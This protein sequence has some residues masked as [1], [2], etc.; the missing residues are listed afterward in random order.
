MSD[1][2]FRFADIEFGNSPTNENIVGVF[3]FEQGRQNRQ[4]PYHIVVA[5]IDSALYA[6]E[7]LLDTI[8]STVEQSR[9]LMAGMALDP[10]ARFEKIIERVNEAITVFQEKEPTPINWDRLNIFIME[11]SGDQLCLSG[12]GKLMNLFLKKQ[13]NEYQTF[14]LCGSLEQPAVTDPNKVFASLICGDMHAGDIFFIG[15]N[16]FERTKD[17]L[18]IKERFSEL[19]MVSAAT[20]VKR[21]LEKENILDDFVALSISLNEDDAPNF[22]DR[23]PK[24]QAEESLNNL[25]KSEDD[26]RQ[27]LAPS[28][29]PLKG[30]KQ[31]SETSAKPRIP[32]PVA[33]LQKTWQKVLHKITTRRIKAT[34][35]SENALRGLHAGRGSFFT[36]QRKVMMGI[37]VVVL[38]LLVVAFSSWQ[39]SKRIAAEQAA[40][41]Q[42]FAEVTDLRNRAENDLLYAKDTQASTKI[43]EAEQI[44]SSLDMGTDD[45]KTRI[46]SLQSEFEQLKNRLRKIVAV[47]GIAELYS[48]P[49]VAQDGMLTAPIMTEEKAYIVDNENRKIVIIT[50]ASREKSEINLPDPAGKIIG[51]S[52]GD[53]SVV[54]MDDKGKFYGVTVADNDFTPLNSFANTSSTND[55]LLYNKRAY[56][57]DGVAGQIYRLGAT[58]AGF[59]GPSTYFEENNDLAKGAVSLAIDSNV[60]IARSNGTITKF[61]SGEQEAFG[62]GTVDPALRSISAIWTDTEDSRLIVTDPAEKR[63]LIF[64]KNGLL[65]AQLTSNEFGTLRDVSSRLNAKQALV[66]SDNRL[67]LVPLP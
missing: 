20:E 21:D 19:P 54:F 34:P 9:T 17:K 59:S 4:G 46:E 15:T 60:Y 18:R 56:V 55:F 22:V 26:V 1:K 37:A 42:S 16:N 27:T 52:L 61:L 2:F 66:V 62:L 35:A 23:K 5:E 53:K 41:E 29:S 28:I 40:W 48:L 50:L 47:S 30:H 39:R 57:L 64:D 58:S 12:H 7:Q 44:I 45:R 6:Y 63:L 25:K 65:T 67:L 51:G 3:R 33:S 38:I 13:G 8:N 32:S 31:E 24:K 10:F 11:C 14:D 43:T 36:T 49:V